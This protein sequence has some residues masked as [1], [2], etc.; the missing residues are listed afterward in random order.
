MGL[1]GGYVGDGLPHVNYIL[2][3]VGLY[4]NVHNFPF[5]L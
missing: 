3:G 1:A 5:S 4:L 2:G